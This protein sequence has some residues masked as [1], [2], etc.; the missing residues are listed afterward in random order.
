MS[1]WEVSDQHTQELMSEFY[2]HLLSGMPKAE[3]L[4]RAKSTIR[5]KYSAPFY[6]ASFILQ[7]DPGPLRGYRR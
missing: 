3:A 6:W 4:A 7:G 2:K 5:T 1:L